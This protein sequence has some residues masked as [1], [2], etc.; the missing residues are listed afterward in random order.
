MVTRQ[1]SRLKMDKS[2][3][4]LSM[5]DTVDKCIDLMIAREKNKIEYGGYTFERY[6][7]ELVPGLVQIVVRNMSDPTDKGFVVSNFTVSTQ[8]EG[9]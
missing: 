6:S 4:E 1:L 5:Q 9:N 2:E 8:K 7:D 3:Q